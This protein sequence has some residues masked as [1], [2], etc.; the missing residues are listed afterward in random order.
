MSYHGPPVVMNVP[1]PP[2][3]H[4][5]K[6]KKNLAEDAPF[7]QPSKSASF[8][9]NL[10][11]PFP[12]S[13][14]SSLQQSVV[15]QQLLSFRSSSL[16]RTKI[17]E[18]I[19]QSWLIKAMDPNEKGFQ[20][21]Q[22]PS[23]KEV[24]KFSEVLGQQ[25]KKQSVDVVESA[26]S[27]KKRKRK[28]TYHS[29][30]DKRTELESY[31][32]FPLVPAMFDEKITVNS[33]RQEVLYMSKRRIQ[34]YCKLFGVKGRTKKLKET[35]LRMA[36]AHGGTKRPAAPPGGGTWETWTTEIS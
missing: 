25:A 17:C 6:M 24:E 10:A 35:L 2:P 3:V 26:N 22:V 30:D 20:L 33:G 4:Y 14:W 31:L 13:K 34:A 23:S 27:G 28:Y 12:H 32:K 5:P 29:N 1:P 19:V 36:G 18:S 16:S 11:P 8:T 21:S 7:H 15:A 9:D